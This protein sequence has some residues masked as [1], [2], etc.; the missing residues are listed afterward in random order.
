MSSAFITVVASSF[1]SRRAALTDMINAVSVS[2]PTPARSS[3]AA[4]AILRSSVVWNVSLFNELAGAEL[5]GAELAG[6]GTVA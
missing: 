5:A 3:S 4:A 1:L 6:A 2:A